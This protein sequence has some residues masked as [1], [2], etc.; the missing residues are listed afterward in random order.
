M[1]DPHRRLAGL[2]EPSSPDDWSAYHAE[3]REAAL[4]TFGRAYEQGL[5]GADPAAGGGDPAYVIAG[6][7]DEELLVLAGV[8]P[9]EGVSCGRLVAPREL[10]ALL[11][12][13]PETSAVWCD[14][15]EGDCLAL[16]ASRVRVGGEPMLLVV[17]RSAQL[18]GETD[19]G[20][21]LTFADERVQQREWTPAGM[22][23]FLRDHD[24]DA[25]LAAESRLA[26]IAAKIRE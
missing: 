10:L 5:L 15:D 14:E 1:S 23:A 17:A 26:E 2:R 24:G 8:W 9:A 11:L 7:P 21:E 6:G 19:A 16:T 13:D 25:L 4:E 20:A 12:S 22:D 18:V 3:A